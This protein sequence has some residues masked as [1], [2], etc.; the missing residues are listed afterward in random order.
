MQKEAVSDYYILNNKL[1]SF[2]DMEIF[3]RIGKNAIYEVIK[4][5]D[6]IPL[7]FE[8]HMDRLRHSAELSGFKIEK[9]D[10]E[11]H[12]EILLLIE[13][14]KCEHI[15]VKLV[16]A[17]SK[18][19]SDEIFLV[20]FI[21]SEY[22]EKDVYDRGIHTILFEAE[23]P[24]PNIKT[25]KGSFRENVKDERKASGAYEALLVDR[26][27]YIS[28]GSRSNVF[29]LKNG[30][31]LTSPAETVLLGVTRQYVVELCNTMGMKVTERSIH[32]NELSEIEGAFITGTTVDVL[33]ISSAGEIRIPSVL[34]PRI[35]KII[36]KFNEK[37]TQY[38]D[39]QKKL[40]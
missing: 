34:Q 31:I 22:P 37:A 8:S 2:Q 24:E 23:R 18:S 7:F 33:P 14:N 10:R 25:L 15:N 19:G 21:H 29:F 9:K 1:C 26:N 12:K 20:Y 3:D 11:I 4:I 16:R 38:I 39:S 35:K 6:S 17:I 32:K 40:L 30:D 27:G 36:N 28:E 13:K 5:I